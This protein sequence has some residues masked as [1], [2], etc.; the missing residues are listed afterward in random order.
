MADHYR[1][2]VDIAADVNAGKADPVEVV[3]AAVERI[4]ERNDVTNAFVTVIAEE[5]R[6]QAREVRER[7][8]AGE[9]LPLAGVPLGI[10]DLGDTKEGVVHTRGLAPLAD[11]VADETALTVRRLEEAG[12]VPVGTTNT[13]ALGHTVRTVNDVVGPT[14]TPFDPERNAGGSSGGSAAALADGL[15]A[16]ATGS[17][18]GGSLRNPAACCN[19]VSVKPTHGLVPNGSDLNGF[20]GHTPV[21]VRGP[22]AR[23]TRSLGRM[24]DVMAGVD[25]I[26]P[27]SVPATDDYEGAAESRDP[28]DLEIAYSPGLDLFPVAPETRDAIESTLGDLESAGATVEEVEL[29]TPDRHTVNETYMT[30]VTAYFAETVEELNRDLGYDLLEEHEGEVPDQLR[31]IVEVGESHDITAYTNSNFPR[32]DLYRAVQE[33]VGDYDALVCPTVATPPL[34]HDE[35]FPPEIDGVET[36]GMPTDWAMAWVF[37]LTGHPV[38]N[39]PADLADGLPVGMQVVGPTFSEADLLGVAATVEEVSPW[40]YPG[41]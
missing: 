30:T 12:A 16:L 17:D 22:M 19:V 34:T 24:L 20:H 32:T 18:V 28:A 3:D 8:E 40:G 23:D 38:V 35:P 9:D 4:E 14:G 6:E 26:D 21:S 41:A 37:N 29:D 10:K 5:A 33:V 27:F 25:P 31:E 11:D 15:V 1:S 39:V 2:A 13:P 7:V 36:E